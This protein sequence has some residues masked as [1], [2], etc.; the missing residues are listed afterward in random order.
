MILAAHIL[1]EQQGSQAIVWFPILPG[2][3]GLVLLGGATFGLLLYIAIGI[4]N[5]NKAQSSSPKSDKEL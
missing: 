4:S 5:L 2:E 1:N 3:I